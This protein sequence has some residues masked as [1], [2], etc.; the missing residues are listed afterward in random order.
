MNTISGADPIFYT[1]VSE[2]SLPIADRQEILRRVAPWLD[3]SPTRSDLLQAAIEYR[4]MGWSVIPVRG[5]KAACKWKPFQSRRPSLREIEDRLAIPGVTGLAVI[6]G[7]ISGWRASRGRPAFKLGIR[8][9]DIADAYYRW[10]ERFP[11]LNKVLPRVRTAR[12]YHVYF[13]SKF[14]DNKYFE[15]GELKAKTS[16]IAVLPPSPFGYWDE[17]GRRITGV[18]RWEQPFPADLT[19]LPILDPREAGFY[20]EARPKPKPKARAAS[21]PTVKPKPKCPTSDFRGGWRRGTEPCGA[22]GDLGDA[23]GGAGTAP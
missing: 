23:A 10:S 9:F 19:A 14:E 16:C 22:G 18:Y 3:N 1:P 4:G 20:G 7:W 2:L 15:D 12:G 8:D 6:T 13:L 21:P 11:D 5:K 17:D